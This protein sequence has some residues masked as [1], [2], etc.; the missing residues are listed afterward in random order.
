[1]S[2]GDALPTYIPGFCERDSETE[3]GGTVKFIVEIIFARQQ[4]GV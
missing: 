3:S 2:K 1:M 4:N